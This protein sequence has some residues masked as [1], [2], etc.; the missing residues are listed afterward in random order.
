[1][2][3][4]L[5][6]GEP[7]LLKYNG[8]RFSFVD[9]GAGEQRL[10]TSDPWSFLNSHLQV[11]RTQVRG[12]NR[13]RIERALYFAALAEDFYRAADCV[14]LPAKGTLLYYGMLDLVKSFLSQWGPTRDQY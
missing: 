5:E 2:S 6:Q 3:R 10:L 8:L 9:L 14:P 4:P 12:Q 13:E 11:R 1:M 7:A